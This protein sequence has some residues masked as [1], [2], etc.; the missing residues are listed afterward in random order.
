[1]RTLLTDSVVLYRIYKIC[2]SFICVVETECSFFCQWLLVIPCV[3]NLRFMNV[4]LRYSWLDELLKGLYGY[5]YKLLFFMSL[6]GIFGYFVWSIHIPKR[7]LPMQR[8][9]FQSIWL[10]HICAE[11]APNHIPTQERKEVETTKDSVHD[12]K[13]LVVRQ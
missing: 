3:D 7:S 10:I 13:K 11:K 4:Y 9:L 6:F 2:I 12:A 8:I 5:F 1:M